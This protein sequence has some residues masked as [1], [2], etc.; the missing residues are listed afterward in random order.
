VFVLGFVL[1]YVEIIFIVVPI[2]CPPLF[3]AG[4]D[5]VWLAV[6]LSLNLQMSFLTPPFGYALFY[7]R[8]V[9]DRRLPTRDIYHAVIPF[10]VIQLIALML[11]AAFPAIATWLPAALY[12]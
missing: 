12:R 7:L 9:A 8:S 10:I 5:P 2:A 1:E 11:V 4:V 6:L 3:M